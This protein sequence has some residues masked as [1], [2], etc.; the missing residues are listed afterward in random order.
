MNLKQIE[1]FLAI[2]HYKNF[3]VAARSLFVSQPAISKQITAMEEELGIVLFY[4]NKQRVVPSPAAELLANTFK[5]MLKSYNKAIEDARTLSSDH[6]K[7]LHIGLS[8]HGLSLPSISK[9][10]KSFSDE[11]HNVR[12]VL[13]DAPFS[14]LRSRIIDGSFDIIITILTN[15]E[16]MNELTWKEFCS[17][18][19]CLVM[20]QNHPLVHKSNLVCSDFNNQTFYLASEMEFPSARKLWSEILEQRGIRP[21][22]FVGLPNVRSM[23]L[24]L[25]DGF[26][27]ALLDTCVYSTFS[28]REKYFCFELNDTRHTIVTAWRKDNINS[29]ILK[30][31]N[32]LQKNAEEFHQ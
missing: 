15:I 19:C 7:I 10:V 21:A 5:E 22:S 14:Q 26:G 8:A 28:Q 12:V 2:V 11:C 6:L 18:P 13:E 27:V 20:S 16:H 3:S 24:N 4:R 29:L 25:E 1:Y 17:V 32:K 23:L 9:A 31:I 30:F